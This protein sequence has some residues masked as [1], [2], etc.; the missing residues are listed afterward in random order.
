MGNYGKAK[1]VVGRNLR[2]NLLLFSCLA[3]GCYGLF[4][5]NKNAIS[6]VNF[7]ILFKIILNNLSIP[8]L[9]PCI[10]SEVKIKWNVPIANETATLNPANKYANNM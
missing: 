1:K 2:F 3:L 10:F 7:A 8:P 6:T 4:A 5:T 9:N